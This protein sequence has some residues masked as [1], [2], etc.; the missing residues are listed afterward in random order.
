MAVELYDASID[1]VDAFLIW[2]VHNGQDPT[3]AQ[4][5]TWLQLGASELYG[6]VGTIPADSPC[7]GDAWHGRARHI[8]A[9]F[10]AAMAED[11]HYPERAKRRSNGEYGSVLWDRHKEQMAALQRDLEACRDG[12]DPSAAHGGAA[13]SFPSPPLFTRCMPS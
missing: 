4:I 13:H 10:A 1:D 11:A 6:L 5:D 8:I 12:L 2:D 7:G 9:L 3:A